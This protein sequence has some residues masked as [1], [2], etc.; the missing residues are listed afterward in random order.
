M[1]RTPLWWK[2]AAPV[3]A[4]AKKQA[5]VL[6]AL[7]FPSESRKDLLD[8][9][10]G[11]CPPGRVPGGTR[12]PPCGGG[13]RHAPEACS[14][15]SARF[16]R[17][18]RCHLRPGTQRCADVVTRAAASRRA[19]R[20]PSAAA[21]GVVDVR[22]RDALA[23]GA[24]GVTPLLPLLNVVRRSLRSS[25]GAQEQKCPQRTAEPGGGPNGNPLV[26]SSPARVAQRA[27]PPS[28]RR[29]EHARMGRRAPRMVRGGETTTHF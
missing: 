4:S 12:S 7:E 18:D 24:P 6:L 9:W 22:V 14:P 16:R 3:V 21:D 11:Q 13:A 29:W 17:T 27:R 26:W 28:T 23:L 1:K 8:R 2:A 25:P 5:L 19:N 10:K 20:S 15:L